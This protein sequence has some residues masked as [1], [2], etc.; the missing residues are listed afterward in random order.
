MLS[1]ADFYALISGD[2]AATV[3]PGTDVS[4]PQNGS[5]ANT[6]IGRIGASSFL[7]SAVGTYLI[8]FEVSVSEAGQLVLTLNGEEL[9]QTV[10]GR[11][12]GASQ[13][14]GMALITTTTP[15]AILT[16]RNPAGNSPTLTITPSAGGTSPVSAHLIIVQLQ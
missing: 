2:N 16:L 10:V 12:A 7:L 4:F 11:V 6:N 14:V 3:A 5:I 9:P 13:I 1:Y 8:L 15:N